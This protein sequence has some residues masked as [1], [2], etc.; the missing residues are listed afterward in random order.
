MT[1]WQDV[2]WFHAVIAHG[3]FSAAARAGGTTQATVSRRIKALEAKLGRALFVRTLDGAA[4]TPFGESLRAPAA[5]MARGATAWERAIDA[6][7]ADRRSIVVTCGELIGGYLSKNL[8]HLQEDLDSIDIELKPTNAF[9]DIARGDA[10]LAL[11]NAR[12]DA[13]PLKGRRLKSNVYGAFSVFGAKRFFQPDQFKE[14]DALKSHAWIAHARNLSHLQSAQWISHHIGD[15]SIRFRM[16]S[17]AL[18][19]DATHT[20]KALALLPR[21]IGLNEDHLVEVFGPV[22]GMAFEMW[23]VRRD[24]GYRDPAMEQLIRNIENLFP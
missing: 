17:T 22:D 20:N 18:I 9:V 15:D 21:F 5:E 14:I 4:L 8:S 24:D 7:N 12:P 16:N 23:I 2:R 10:D 6:L 11:R 1:D 3:G 19:L 13:G